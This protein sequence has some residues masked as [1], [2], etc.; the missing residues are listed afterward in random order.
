[1]DISNRDMN[2]EELVKCIL[3]ITQRIPTPIINKENIALKKVKKNTEENI[4]IGLTNAEILKLIN[5]T[6]KTNYTSTNSYDIME[7]LCEQWNKGIE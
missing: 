6:F 5:D 7:A 4:D 3:E 1:M 2:L